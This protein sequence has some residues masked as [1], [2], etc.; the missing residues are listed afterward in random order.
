MSNPIRRNLGAWFGTVL[1]GSDFG[2]TGGRALLD[3]IT[4]QPPVPSFGMRYGNNPKSHNGG[5]PSG[6]A[7]AKRAARK[8]RNVRKH[9][10]SAA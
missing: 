10:R 5:Q 1:L 9:P 6:A 8:R 7:A 3:A 2:G 4:S